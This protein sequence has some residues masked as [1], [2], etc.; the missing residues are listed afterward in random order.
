MGQ[1]NY[2]RALDS[3]SN[4]VMRER[5]A[6][7]FRSLIAARARPGRSLSLLCDLPASEDPTPIVLHADHDPAV[8]SRLVVQGLTERPDL[9][10]GESV[11]GPVRVLPLR[12][13]VQYKH[14]EATSRSGFREFEHLSIAVR[15]AK[16]R[17]R[18]ASDHEMDA[19]RLA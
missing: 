18:S 12:V 6:R 4:T 2:T 7:P 5:I 11:G 1:K 13:V 16:G 9:G 8:L 19:F 15:V 14:G 3:Q 17:V 10:R